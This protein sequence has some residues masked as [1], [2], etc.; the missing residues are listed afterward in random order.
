MQA[1]IL[2]YLFSVCLFFQAII[3]LAASPD[4]H[5]DP[6]VKKIEG[7]N[8]SIS[9]VFK[10]AREIDEAR[11]R[12]YFLTASSDP[13]EAQSGASLMLEGT[14]FYSYPEGGA[15]WTWDRLSRAT[16]Q[17]REEQLIITLTHPRLNKKFAYFIE[18]TGEDWSVQQRWPKHDTQPIDPQTL[19]RV[20]MQQPEDAVDMQPLLDTRPQSLSVLLNGGPN[21]SGWKRRTVKVSFEEASPLLRALKLPRSAKIQAAIKDAK[22]GEVVSLVPQ[23]VW[24]ENGAY[25]WGGTALGVK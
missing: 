12:I 13:H 24:E 1:P 19:Q 5:L 11:L 15:G 10:N 3:P 16:V 22:S 2:T 18:V 23:M 20:Q 8:N 25:A 21:L 4:D 9:L 6:Q 17:R 7:L 14:S